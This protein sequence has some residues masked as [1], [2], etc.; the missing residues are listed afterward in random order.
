[1]LKRP[2]RSTIPKVF[3]FRI[4]GWSARYQKNIASTCQ[5]GIEGSR[6]FFTP[7][8][9]CRIRV[10]DSP[11]PRGSTKIV[12]LHTGPRFITNVTLGKWQA[13]RRSQRARLFGGKSCFLASWKG[14]Q[15][16]CNSSA[17]GR[18][19]GF[20]LRTTNAIVAR[21]ASSSETNRGRS[22]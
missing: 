7:G 14:N 13:S 18:L 2:E 21:E 8:D 20:M 3:S 11:G 1:M 10:V 6:T 16:E 9:N 17:P 4:E 22:S 5:R 12:G 19:T 15:N